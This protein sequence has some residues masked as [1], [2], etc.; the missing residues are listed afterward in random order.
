MQ[1]ETIQEAWHGLKTFLKTAKDT[2]QR[3]RSEGA[4][5][6]TGYAL[7]CFALLCFAMLCFALLCF[8]LLYL[9]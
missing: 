8:A 5:N 3:D 6:K 4:M 2:C 7:L 1:I 9:T